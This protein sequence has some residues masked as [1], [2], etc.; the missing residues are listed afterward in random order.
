MICAGL[1]IGSRT[2]KLVAMRD[3]KVVFS[4]VEDSGLDPIS[5]AL[6]LVG[7]VGP[8]VLVVTGYGRTSFLEVY[9]SSPVKR[10]TEIKAHAVGAKH[11]FHDCG[12]V[13]D[14]GGQDSKAISLDGD[15]RILDFRMNDRCAAGTGGFL[16][17]MAGALGL[18][19]GDM[20]SV[21]VIHTPSI[22]INS[23]CT[24]FAESE[25]IS[26][27]SKR[28]PVEEVVLAVHYAM[29][30]RVVSLVKKVGVRKRVVFTGGVARNRC[31]RAFL[32]RSLGILVSVPERPELVGAL[33][34]AILTEE[35]FHTER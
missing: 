16:E 22:R 14:I 23:M 3:E 30:K 34:A 7:R 11:I 2:V 17:V 4:A 13:I 31:L 10:V 32:E 24:V 26:L 19:V 20:G 6:D 15:G 21:E 1:D 29:A 8:D 12:T 35:L 28:V 18:S 27:L 33:G 9:S 25:V 5:K